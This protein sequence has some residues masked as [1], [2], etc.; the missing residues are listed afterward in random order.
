MAFD[1]PTASDV[2]FIIAVSIVVAL[3][4]FPIVFLMAF[5]YSKLVKDHPKTPKIM[6]M[7]LATFFGVL[8]AVIGIYLYV[9]YSFLPFAYPA[10]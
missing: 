7:I 9:K 10:G 3:V 6:L 1:F 5:Y 2:F 8:I 4:V